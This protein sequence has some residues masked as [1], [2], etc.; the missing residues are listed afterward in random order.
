MFSCCHIRHLN[1]LKTHPK[2]ITKVHRQMISSPN[3]GDIKFP[4]S[5][6]NYGRIEKKSSIVINVFG[7]E[8][9]LIYPA[10]ILDEKFEDFMDLLSITDDSNS[11]YVYRMIRMIVIR[12]IFK[13]SCVRRQNI[14]YGECNINL[15]MIKKIPV[16]FY[17]LRGCD[18]CLIMQEV[19]REKKMLYQTD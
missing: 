16:I 10:H 13:G 19:C 9:G 11:Y 8:N 17:N 18:S 1:P 6:K 3:Y 5:K 14:R 2:S 7:H 15:K 12:I 4:V